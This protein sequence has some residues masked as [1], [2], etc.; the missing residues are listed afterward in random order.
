MLNPSSQIALQ[1]SRKKTVTSAWHLRRKK[2]A[3]SPQQTDSVSLVLLIMY[4]L[5]TGQVLSVASG[6]STKL[7]FFLKKYERKTD[8]KLNSYVD[9]WW[10]FTT[11]KKNQTAQ[12]KSL[13][14]ATFMVLW[15]PEIFFTTYFNFEGKTNFLKVKF[16]MV[17]FTE[18]AHWADSV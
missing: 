11:T 12:E 9:F 3:T 1:L 8:S 2:T 18:S 13:F 15:H 5:P 6:K 10:F 7:N 17:M 16:L 14:L 4:V